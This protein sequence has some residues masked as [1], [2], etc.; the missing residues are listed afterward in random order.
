MFHPH[1]NGKSHSLA[2]YY[3]FFFFLCQPLELIFLSHRDKTESNEIVWLFVEDKNMIFFCLVN[4]PNLFVCSSSIFR[5][6]QMKSHPRRIFF[7]FTLCYVIGICK[8]IQVCWVFLKM[9]YIWMTPINT[10]FS[11]LTAINKLSIHNFNHKF[12]LIYDT[13]KEPSKK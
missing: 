7:R 12:W 1:L 3:C 11:Q 10:S 6:Q 8:F 9:N 5:T 4:P 13:S 2:H